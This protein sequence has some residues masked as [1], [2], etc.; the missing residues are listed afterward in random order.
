MAT[1]ARIGVAKAAYFPDISLTGTG[2]Y[3]SIP[4]SQ[5]FAGQY[6]L[7]NFTGQLAQPLFAGG[8]LK[9]GVQLAQATQQEAELNYQRT[10]R[11]AFREVSDALV[12]YEKDHEFRTQQ[13]MLTYSAKDAS[14]LSDIRYRGGASSYLEV[15][16]SNTRTYAAELTL[17]QAQLNEMLDYIQLY[18]AL[19]GGWQK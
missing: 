6:G 15:L 1:N 19:G 14:R 8:T 7:W 10:I 9:S 12:A 3:Q 13:E 11:Q 16:D 5:L 17:V 18:R 4:L 2:G